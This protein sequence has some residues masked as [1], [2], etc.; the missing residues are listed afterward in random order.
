M[1]WWCVQCSEI[2][3]KPGN[4]HFNVWRLYSNQLLLLHTHAR[5][6]SPISIYRHLYYYYF[7]RTSFRFIRQRIALPH[8]VVFIS[9]QL[10]FS[11]SQFT[12]RFI[13]M[14]RSAFIFKSEQTLIIVTCRW[15]VV[16]VVAFRLCVRWHIL[17]LALAKTTIP[18]LARMQRKWIFILHFAFV[19]FVVSK[20]FNVRTS[21][22]VRYSWLTEWKLNPFACSR[23][24]IFSSHFS[25]TIKSTEM[26]RLAAAICIL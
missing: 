12:Y 11:L 18:C 14:K 24:D 13:S 20:C 26:V 15:C 8:A 1:W 2:T 17:V 7:V 19:N 10:L 21:D 3:L 4:W 25:V 9:S 22:S 5:S 6:L 16:V 23:F